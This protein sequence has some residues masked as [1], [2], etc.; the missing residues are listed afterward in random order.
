MIEVEL[1]GKLPHFDK[2]LKKFE[3]IGE[4]VKKKKRVSMIYYR[5]EVPKDARDVKDELVDLRLRVTNGEAELVLKYGVWGAEE[6]REEIG[7]PIKLGD[8]DKYVE[9]LKCLGWF[10]GLIASTQSNVFN[11]KGIE[12]ALVKI[13]TGHTYF[14]AEVMAENEEIAE[15]KKENIK[16]VCGELGLEIYSERE[17]IE[18]I[19]ELNSYESRKF[20]LEKEDF[21]SI[22]KRYSEFFK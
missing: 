13:D 6:K 18:L 10:R 7:I 20:N 2:T 19:N 21:T 22:R 4:F 11:Y 8:F 3:E 14:E 16:T 5:D 9:L 17:F 1:R 12:F 15:E